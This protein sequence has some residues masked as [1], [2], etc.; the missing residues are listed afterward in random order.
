MGPMSTD[1][2]GFR[3]EHRERIRW[4]DLDAAGVLNN[5]VYLTLL[6]QARWGYFRRLGL[7]ERD[8]FPFLLGE[9]R[10]RYLAPG[11]AGDEVLVRAR[12]SRLGTKSFDMEYELEGPRGPLALGWA[13]LVWVADDLTSVPI[14]LAARAALAAFEGLQDAEPSPA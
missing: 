9:S 14:P 8:R 13:T 10:V 3:F 5:A 12:V 11:R 4:V 6:E 1:E 7:V 2:P